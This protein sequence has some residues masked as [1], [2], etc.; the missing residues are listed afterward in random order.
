MWELRL[1]GL[2]TQSIFAITV[3]AAA[4]DSWLWVPYMYI[5]VYVYAASALTVATMSVH[6]IIHISNG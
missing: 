3:N 2:M 6:P 1:Q 5:Y 4:S